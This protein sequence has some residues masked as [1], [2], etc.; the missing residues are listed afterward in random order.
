MYG[1]SSM[2]QMLRALR[3]FRA[4]MCHCCVLLQ[5]KWEVNGTGW[6]EGRDEVKEVNWK[7]SRHSATCLPLGRKSQLWPSFVD[8]ETRYGAS[9]HGSEA[10]QVRILTV[11]GEP[12]CE[13]LGR[14][15]LTRARSPIF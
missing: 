12:E 7:E 11:A 15:R 2:N 8:I 9:E 1:R 5:V 13:R 3:L 4:A 14:R 6:K 10:D